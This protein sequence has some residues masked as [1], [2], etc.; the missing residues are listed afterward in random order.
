VTLDEEDRQRRLPAGRKAQLAAYVAETGQVTVSALAERFGVSIDTIRRDLDQLSAEGVLVRT[1]GGAVSQSTLSRV[2][3][4]VDVRLKMEERE[5]EKIAVLAGSL[6][7]DGSIVMINGG[8]TTL[9]VA[10]NLRN[11]RDLT[12]VTNSLLVPPALPTSA[13]RDVYVVGGAVRTL[14]LATIGPVSFRA[15]GG[16]ELDIS[17]DLALIGVGAVSATA[18]YTTSNLAEAAMMR[19]MISRAARVAIL[20]DSSKFGR[21]LFAQVAE[22]GG[23]DYLVTDSTP[24]PD[25]LE[26]LR[27]SEVEVITPE[28]LEGAPETSQDPQ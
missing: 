4:A 28:N 15:S 20:A 21:R 3:R 7:E 14:T 11:H 5:K 12:V 26:A 6:V 1:Y 27:E 23:A 18:G 10:R 13:V 16:S 22:L 17:C 19:E 8:T 25:L 9:A 24:P 2:D